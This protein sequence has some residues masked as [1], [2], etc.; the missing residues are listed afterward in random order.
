MISLEELLTGLRN[1]EILSEEEVQRLRA[2]ALADGDRETVSRLATELVDEGKLTAYQRSLILQGRWEHVSLG[3]YLLLEKIGEG[4]MGQV[5]LAL[6]RHMQ[7]Q[8]ALKLLPERLAA[9]EESKQRFRREIQTLAK[10]SHPNI[11]SAYDAREDHGMLYLVMEFVEGETLHDLVKRR[12]PLPVPEAVGLRSG[13]RPEACR[14]PTLAGSS[15]AISNP[16]TCC[17]TATG[18]SRSSIWAWHAWSDHRG[19]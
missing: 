7:R 18:R 1:L 13:R 8:V 6:H 4:G 15:I 17:A 16:R 5:Y 14:R 2:T 11:V 12:G 19:A 9:S 10:L 3:D